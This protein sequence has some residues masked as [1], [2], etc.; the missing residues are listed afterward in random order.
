MSGGSERLDVSVVLPTYNESASLPVLIPRIV[1]ALD[2]AGLRRAVIVV[3][4]NPPDGTAEV[5][6]QLAREYPVRVQKRITERGLGT[7]VLAG[8]AMS[9]AEVCVV[10][11][12][13]GSHPVEALGGMVRLI[14][15]DKAE[16]VVGS[17]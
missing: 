17:R 12:A 2:S 11:D 1:R 14:L 7:A 10:M 3:D 6:Q 16:I 13:D 5:G 4:D 9:E 8:F 15:D